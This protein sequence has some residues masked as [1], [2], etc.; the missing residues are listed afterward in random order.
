MPFVEVSIENGMTSEAAKY[1]A[2]MPDARRRAQQ[3][4]RIGD[5]QAAAEAAAQAKVSI[6]C[7]LLDFL[8]TILF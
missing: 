2:K 3:F 4:E 1:I 8:L 6:L 5:L 7:I